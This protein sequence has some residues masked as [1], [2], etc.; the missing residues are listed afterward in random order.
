M[1]DRGERERDHDEEDEHDDRH[2]EPFVSFQPAL[3]VIES[4]VRPGEML[5][6]HG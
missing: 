5:V 1:R 2:P 4:V 6:R 3:K